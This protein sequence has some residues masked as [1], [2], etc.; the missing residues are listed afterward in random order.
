MFQNTYAKTEAKFRGDVFTKIDFNLSAL[1]RLVELLYLAF[2]FWKL[3]PIVGNIVGELISGTWG[4]ILVSFVL[5]FGFFIVKGV[6]KLI[7]SSLEHAFGI[8][9]RGFF[10]RFASCFSLWL[11]FL[12]YLSLAS[13]AV[14]MSLSV[15]STVP[16]AL[17]YLCLTWVGLFFIYS[18]RTDLYPAKENLRAP[19]EDEIPPNLDKFS[20][21]FESFKKPVDISNILV[22]SAFYKGLRAPFVT[23]ERLV[24]PEKCLASFTPAALRARI[25]MALLTHMV[26]ASKSLLILRLVCFALAVPNTLILLNSLGLWAGYPVSKTA[27]ELLTLIWMGALSAF[28]FADFASLF[29]SRFLDSKVAATSAALTM[30]ANGLFQSVDIMAAYNLDPTNESLFR[31]IFR[32][33][34]SP[35]AQFKVIRDTIQEMAS[36]AAAKGQ[37]KVFQEGRE[38]ITS[39]KNPDLTLE[40]QEKVKDGDSG[41]TVN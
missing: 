37:A 5:L 6:I 34:S 3:A 16:W 41:N 31:D 25:V 20:F 38:P 8:D 17:I 19:K 9:P 26:S 22:S 32:K 24:V 39:P 12:P 29:V 7:R 28:W 18:F 1:E 33:R 2:A 10:E 27:P 14:F 23:K 40:K 30:D 36:T 21:L 4:I 13:V 15:F 35:I 11:I